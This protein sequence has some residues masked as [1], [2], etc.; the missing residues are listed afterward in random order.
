MKIP[1]APFN[2]LVVTLDKKLYDT[3]TF[4]SGVTLHIDP[5]WHPEEFSMLKA[6]VVSVPKGISARHDYKDLTCDIKPGD[7]ILVRYDLVFH[8]SSQPDRDSPVYRNMFL[9]HDENTQTLHEYWMCDIQKVFGVF[10]KDW[11]EMKNGYVYLMP[12]KKERS[13][14]SKLILL[15]DELIERNSLNVAKIAAIQA[16]D[17]KQND[18]VYFNPDIVQKYSVDQSVFWIVK[19]SHILAKNH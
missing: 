6:T 8:Y 18:V 5:T 2:R 12:I 11:I 13:L 10:T 1:V 7:E 15:P 14:P 3:V 17:F 19:R 4:E 9:M 16:G